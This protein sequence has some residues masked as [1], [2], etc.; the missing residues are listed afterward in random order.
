MKKNFLIATLMVIAIQIIV[1]ILSAINLYYQGEMHRVV[2]DLSFGAAIVFLCA[3]PVFMYFLTQRSRL[4][5]MNTVLEEATRRASDADVAKSEFLANMSHEIRTPMNGV[6]GMAE[7]LIKTELNDKQKMFA[8]VIVKSG[9]SLLMIINDVLDFSKIESGQLKLD[10]APFD[11]TEVVEDVASLLSPK[12]AEK[13]IELIVRISPKVP[14]LIVGDNGR[15]RQLLIN[16]LGNAVK[17]TETGHVYLEISGKFCDDGS[18]IELKFS[19]EDTGI[20]ISKEDCSKVFEK[21][22]QADGSA[23]RN[24]EGT[25]LG[26][27]ISSSL[28]KLMGGEIGVDSELGLGSTF[29]F[30]IK[31]PISGSSV[32]TNQQ[33]TEVA[34]GKV[35]IVDD[36]AI[37][38]SLLLEQMTL[39]GLEADQ[40]SS[41]DEAL[42]MAERAMA[43]SD[44]YD[45]MIL[46]YQMPGM[47][48][49]DVAKEFRSREHLR[50]M[51]IIMLTSVDEA[52]DGSSF[53]RLGIEAYLVKPARSSQLFKHVTNTLKDA[54]ENLVNT[55]ENLKLS[56]DGA[57]NEAISGPLVDEQIDILV[58]EDNEV[59]QIVFT[60]ILEAT[61]WRFMIAE[62]GA[63]AVEFNK[64]YQPKIILMDISMPVMNGREACFAI[65]SQ[66]QDNNID[67]G[68]PI[69]AVTAHAI[70]GDEQK[71]IDA[72]MDD[73]LA[74]PVSP[75]ILEAKIDHWMAELVEREFSLEHDA[76]VF[77]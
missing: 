47:T 70:S 22:S 34:G 67:L 10:P 24:Y 33:S 23:T 55:T 62:N 44:G 35:L 71:C 51:P 28:V 21:F 16:M 69:I 18:N 60:Q 2:Y 3:Y 13:N 63:Q 77:A 11:L 36:N 40:A 73:Y 29:W 57:A 30:N 68:V 52:E 25:G 58:A 8:D 7:L 20:G 65:R 75:Q 9:A 66:E 46:D 38:R 53:A 76:L 32:K 15:I 17:F 37:N 5:E 45:L 19:I 50:S 6:M 1:A 72:G 64:R 49:G 61:N 41:G 43:V 31:L 12:F 48:G 4:I 56:V 59:N 26:L 54:K 39:W 42:A 74:K 27:S 14:D